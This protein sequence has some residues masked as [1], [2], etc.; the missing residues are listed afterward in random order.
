MKRTL[1][2]THTFLYFFIWG[3][4]HY[5][6]AKNC[7]YELIGNKICLYFDITSMANLDVNNDGDFILDNLDRINTIEVSDDYFIK[8]L[9]RNLIQNASSKLTEIHSE[10]FIKFPKNLLFHRTI[11]GKLKSQRLIMKIKLES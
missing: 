5:A 3:T 6:V 10:I 1:R 8:N 11:S 4:P 2:T 7:E 9:S